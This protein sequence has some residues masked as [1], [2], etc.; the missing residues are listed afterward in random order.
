MKT[1]EH[2]ELIEDTIKDTSTVSKIMPTVRNYIRDIEAGKGTKD[3]L[4]KPNYL[5]ILTHLDLNFLAEGAEV[6]KDGAKKYSKDNWK[7]DLEPERITK[8]LLRHLVKYANGEKNDTESNKSH[9]CHI[10]ANC[11]FLYYYDHLKDNGKSV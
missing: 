10:L 8:A 1:D 2:F 5:D 4:N 11:M 9:L 6:M 7:K 3:D